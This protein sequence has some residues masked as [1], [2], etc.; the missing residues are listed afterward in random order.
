MA[1]PIAVPCDGTMSVVISFRYIL[2][3]TKSVVIGSC[4]YASPA[5]TTRPTLSLSSLSI[6]RDRIYFARSRRDIPDGSSLDDASIDRDTSIAIITSMPSDRSVSS[7]SPKRGRAMAMTRAIS[8]ISCKISL[9]QGL[10]RDASGMS[11]VSVDMCPYFSSFC[12][13]AMRASR[14]RPVITGTSSNRYNSSGYAKLNIVLAIYL[15]Q[16]IYLSMVFLRAISN[17][18]SPSAASAQIR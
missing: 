11:G 15:T 10:Y 5:K 13:L 12:F 8:A 1:V 14:K 16:G 7:F 4:V 2:A 9:I 6:R 3:D 18:R 17:T